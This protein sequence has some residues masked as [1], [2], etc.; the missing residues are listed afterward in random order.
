VKLCVLSRNPAQKARDQV[1]SVD[2]GVGGVGV[3]QPTDSVGTACPLYLADPAAYFNL[4]EI[5][6]LKSSLKLQRIC[7]QI[8]KNRPAPF[9]VNKNRIE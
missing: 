8:G 4:K 9:P 1:L 6:R 7:S 2:H 5:D 3:V